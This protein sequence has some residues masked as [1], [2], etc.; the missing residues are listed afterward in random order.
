MVKLRL[1]GDQDIGGDTAEPR[2]VHWPGDASLRNSSTVSCSASRITAET[3]KSSHSSS[4]LCYLFMHPNTGYQTL[5]N[6]ITAY[7]CQYQ[8]R[9]TN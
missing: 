9:K 1:R 5:L 8:R 3:V 4:D 7:I 2:P 6:G